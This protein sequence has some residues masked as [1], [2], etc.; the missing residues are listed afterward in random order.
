MFCSTMD[1]QTYGSPK[2][3]SFPAVIIIY[4]H[5][6]IIIYTDRTTSEYIHLKISP[7]YIVAF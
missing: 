6:I 4:T 3:C 1:C 7:S 5:I 2:T